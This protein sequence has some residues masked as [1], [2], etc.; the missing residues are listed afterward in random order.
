MKINYSDGWIGSYRLDN[1]TH[2][3]STGQFY[4]ADPSRIG[5]SVGGTYQSRGSTRTWA[6]D[7]GGSLSPAAV[8][9]VA[10]VLGKWGAT[11]NGKQAAAVDAAVYALEGFPT[12]QLSSNTHGRKRTDAAGVTA[13]AQAMVAEAKARAAAGSY[14]LRVDI[15]S[16]VPAHSRYK[17]T[18]T[19]RN[20]AGRPVPGE[21]VTLVD[22]RHEK[23]TVT[24]NKAG[25]GSASFGTLDRAATVSAS[26]TL[27]ATAVTYAIPSNKKAQRVFV[28][29]AKTTVKAHDGASFP[30]PPPPPVKPR[31]GTTATDKADGDHMIAAQG[32]TVVDTVSYS[33]LVPGK[34]YTVS[35][36]L[37]DKATG[38]STGVKASRTFTPAKATGTVSVE[39]TVP[40]NV[41]A[42]KQLV[43]FEHVSLNGKA[44]VA[45]TDI[46]DVNQTVKVGT[47][48]PPPPV[49]PR[50]GTTATDKADGDHMIPA[51]GG[52]VVDTVSYSGLIPG[53][54]YQVSGELMDKA[55]GKS[56]GVKASR[57]FTPAKATGTVSVEF[58]VPANVVAGR[59]L[60]AFEHVRQNGKDVA[61]HTDINDVNQT[62]WVPKVGTTAVDKADGDHT[63]SVKGGTVVDTVRYEGLEPGKTYQVSGE[64]MDRHTGKPTGIK[65]AATFTATKADGTVDV[66]YTV[67]AGTEGREFVV[68]ETVTRGGKQIASHTDLKDSLQTIW[69]SVIGTTAVDKADGDH[70]L[71]AQGGTIVDTVRFE[72][73]EPGKTYQVSG[74]LMDR[75]TGKPTGIKG[76][77]TF[78]ATKADGTVDVTYTVPAGTEGREFVVFETVTRG[79]KQIASHTDLK[80]SL[81]TIWQSVIGTTAVDKADGDH[82]IVAQGGTI[83]D[84]VRFEGLEPGKTYQVSG[85]L[86]DK[87]TGKS[88]GIKGTAKFTA[89]QSSGAIEVE[90]AVPSGYAGRGLVAF[91]TVSDGVRVI[92]EHRDLND[93]SQTVW[94]PKVGTTAV[95]KADKDHVLAAQGGTI[96]DTVRYEGLEPGK[97]YQV[98]GELM[99]RRTGKPTGIKA[100]AAFTATQSSGAIEVEFA[101]PSGYAGRGLVA[102]ETI[103]MGGHIVGA[104]EDLADG[105]QM[106]SVSRPTS[107]HGAASGGGIHTGDVP[108]GPDKG[109]IAGGIVLLVLAG[110]C[111][112]AARL[113]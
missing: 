24:T 74:E 51:S 41:V 55:T 15:P 69:Q 113:Q 111:W 102:F 83:V 91:E 43:A 82:M 38:K 89:T 110:G 61:V 65:G 39:F 27:P 93:H 45:H 3:G 100:A 99:D 68:F 49:K 103:R 105:A 9:Q 21:K 13:Q 19:L 46:N 96:V 10:W 67:P 92:A 6:R 35:G 87:A 59:E 97:T 94:V 14:K 107:G 47:P 112:V 86:M 28:S 90:F 32:G 85:E 50:L 81:Q 109:L 76:A 1:K 5:P 64:L 17:A 8:A 84:T 63:V 104:H 58:T 98:S 80:D 52:T 16:Q 56:T 88:T 20:G 71:V 11:S 53:K 101:V 44:V 12:H 79:G 70:M 106:V 23:V 95:D 33:G 4:C 77:A 26:A 48:P 78:T 60:V 29:G 7:G 22:G 57:T 40:A 66:T 31:I 2:R 37:M 36:E 72:G 75:H 54:T 25:V 30:P 34:K 18:V 62:V 42:G 73:L 108:G